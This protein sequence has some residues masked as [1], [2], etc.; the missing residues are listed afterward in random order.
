M[1]LRRITIAFVMDLRGNADQ[2]ARAYMRSIDIILPRSLPT[3]ST[4]DHRLHLLLF[5]R[6]STALPIHRTTF[7]H[8]LPI[9]RHALI[10]SSMPPLVPPFCTSPIALTFNTSFSSS[11]GSFIHEIGHVTAYSETRLPPNLPPHHAPCVFALED[12]CTVAPIIEP[13]RWEWEGARCERG[14]DTLHCSAMF[15][16]CCDEKGE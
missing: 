7:H 1:L 6:L 5:T 3:I 11:S 10:R 9:P 16:C 15:V 12:N 4:C 8:A 2:D 13:G 14:L